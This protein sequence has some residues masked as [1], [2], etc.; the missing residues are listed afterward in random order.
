MPNRC[1]Q[2]LKW[3][4]VLFILVLV[5][6]SYYAYVVQMCIC[7]LS[8][9]KYLSSIIVIILATIDNLPKKS[10][11]FLVNASLRNILFFF[12]FSNLFVFLSS[13]LNTFSVVLLPNSI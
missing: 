2:A 6:W 1:C 4:P 10:E 13:I 3:T 9:S 7:K 8:I 12:I 5:G 11:E